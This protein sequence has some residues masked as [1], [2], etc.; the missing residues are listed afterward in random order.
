MTSEYPTP[1]SK[2]GN[3]SAIELYNNKILHLS[4]GF[5]THKMVFEVNINECLTCSHILGQDMQVHCLHW[6]RHQVESFY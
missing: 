4:L 3:K 2:A 5:K 1:K 6:Q